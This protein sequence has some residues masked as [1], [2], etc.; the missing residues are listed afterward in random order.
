MIRYMNTQTIN[1]A[2]YD[3]LNMLKGGTIRFAIHQPGYHRHLYYYYKMLVSDVFI[4][5]DT[6][7]FVSGEW[8]NRQIFYRGDT[9]KWL[10]VPICKGW[11]PICQKVIVE[12]KFL[13]SHWDIIRSIY[14]KTP[15]F[16]EFRPALEA[17]YS[18]EWVYLNDLCDELTMLARQALQ[19][20]TP[21]I[22]SSSYYDNPVKL[23]KGDLLADCILQ[24]VDIQDYQA[25]V[26]YPRQNPLPHTHYLNQVFDDSGLTEKQKMEMKGVIVD[27]FVFNE[28]V[29]TQYQFSPGTPFRSNLSIFDLLFN[30]GPESA[31]ILRN[32]GIER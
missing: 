9:P 32:C 23:A 19:I 22:R 11:E 24:L 29:Y 21:Y 15:Y 17:I 27:G 26:Y 18:R 3:R 13:V 30:H 5:L 8:Q 25:V 4:S 10:T 28:P 1:S 2:V 7:Q 14:K 6:A 20:D 12:Q 31:T 16:N